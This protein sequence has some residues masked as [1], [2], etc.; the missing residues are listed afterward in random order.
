MAFFTGNLRNDMLKLLNQ[1]SKHLANLTVDF[2]HQYEDYQFLTVSETLGLVKAPVRTIIVDASSAV[3]G[4]PGHRE[5]VLQLNRDH[6][7]ICKFEGNSNSDFKLVARHLKRL[8]DAAVENSPNQGRIQEDPEQ[9]PIVAEPGATPPRA[10]PLSMLGSSPQPFFVGQS[11]MLRELEAFMDSTKP[12]CL[13]IT[14]PA[15]AGKSATVRKFAYGQQGRYSIF[16][17][18]AETPETIHTGIKEATLK[19]SNQASSG[20]TSGNATSFK[21]W[22]AKQHVPWLIVFDNACDGLDIRGL[23]PT[24]KGKV[25][26]T[27]RHTALRISADFITKEIAPLSI[28]EAESLFRE[29]WERRRRSKQQSH[30]TSWPS[31]SAL[32][33]LHGRPLAIVLAASHLAWT[34]TNWG[35]TLNELNT[36]VEETA[37]DAANLDELIWKWVW[38]VVRE[39]NP[40]EIDLLAILTALDSTC[41]PKDLLD[42]IPYEPL[43]PRMTKLEMIQIRTDHEQQYLHIPLAI[44]DCSHR[45]LEMQ[46]DAFQQDILQQAVTLLDTVLCSFNDPCSLPS[47]GF[48][49]ALPHV[50]KLCLLMARSLLPLEV[51]T[52]NHLRMLSAHALSKACSILAKRCHKQ[53]WRTWLL[54][55]GFDSPEW[56]ATE[57]DGSEFIDPVV[58][59]SWTSAEQNSISEQG[60]RLQPAVLGPLCSF[61]IDDLEKCLMLGAIG[62]CWHGIREDVFD[63][64]RQLPNAP[65]NSSRLEA[66]NDAI[67]KGATHGLMVATKETIQNEK[68]RQQFLEVGKRHTNRIVSM[69]TVSLEDYYNQGEFDE[70]RLKSVITISLESYSL[71]AFQMTSRGFADLFRNSI[72]GILCSALE[73]HFPRGSVPE[74]QCFE[75]SASFIMSACSKSALEE[76]SRKIAK[77]Y[78]EVIEAMS[79]SIASDVIIHCGRTLIPQIHPLSSEDS[80]AGQSYLVENLLN[81]AIELTREGIIGLEH[82]RTPLWRS[83]LRQAA[84]WCEQAQQCSN[85]WGTI[86]IERNFRNQDRWEENCIFLELDATSQPVDWLI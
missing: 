50:R 60:Q 66:I 57:E 21:D 20:R 43:L 25:I 12:D 85:A 22:L 30:A 3:I 65:Q 36:L 75:R 34:C 10:V 35:S 42:S 14:G 45:Y 76:R 73:A 56:S 77:G 70:D 84:F 29:T 40:P 83:S 68:M 7:Q 53:F 41:V 72:S 46:P 79:F 13:V 23:Y 67:E 74:L 51:A 18:S 5:H 80:S 11:G 37:P 28:S 27:S 19:I 86:H 17:F 71:L 82:K 16:W 39:L 81:K 69:I 58:L 44:R 8:A 15:G 64:V 2:S 78:W 47:R 32:T 31:S 24:H 61:F 49:T 9:R 4:L 63:F 59:P 48:E 62:N 33:M 1:S 55:N 38:L 26:I 54:S 52:V 6:R